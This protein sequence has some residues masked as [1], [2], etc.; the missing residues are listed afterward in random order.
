MT[1]TERRRPLEGVPPD[2]APT[3]SLTSVRNRPDIA[4][5]LEHFQFRVLQDALAEASNDHW[6]RRAEAFEAARP[7]HGDFH[8]QAT[9]E[10]LQ[11]RWD[12]LT[13]QTQACRAAAQV[14]LIRY[15]DQPE[16]RYA[17]RA[18]HHDGDE[19]VHHDGEQLDRDAIKISGGAA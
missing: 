7:R 15:G 4:A 19:A 9:H 1:L 5:Y 13:E 2:P 8:G 3:K 18:V 11:A 10:A 16:V 14:A 6:L 12:R 17:D